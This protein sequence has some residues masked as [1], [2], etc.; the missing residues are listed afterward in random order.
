MWDT[1]HFLT[2]FLTGPIL[3]ARGKT[4]IHTPLLNQFSEEILHNAYLLFSYFSHF[5]CFFPEPLIFCTW[6]KK[7]YKFRGEVRHR[8]LFYLNFFIFFYSRLKTHWMIASEVV[9]NKRVTSAVRKQKVSSLATIL[10]PR[11]PQINYC[12]TA[13][14]Q[15]T[16]VYFPLFAAH[17]YKHRFL[18]Y[19]TQWDNFTFKNTSSDRL[20]ATPVT[21]IVMSQK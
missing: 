20:S 18:Q 3:W 9:T 7:T 2:P 16:N 11:L 19:Q 6:N 10:G 14:I 21:K 4:R 12:I 5:A 1:F 17:T 13:C 15:L 8:C